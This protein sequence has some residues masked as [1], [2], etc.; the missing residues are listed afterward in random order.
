MPTKRRAS[1]EA[2]AR[3]EAKRRQ[4]ALAF[5]KDDPDLARLERLA[6]RYGSRKAAIVAGLRALEPDDGS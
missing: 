5:R 3:Y 4:V 6:L 2:E 1:P